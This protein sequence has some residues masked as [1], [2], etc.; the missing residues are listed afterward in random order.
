MTR[1]VKLYKIPEVLET[2]R[3]LD[4]SVLDAYNDSIQSFNE[5]AR[6]TLDKFGK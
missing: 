1:Q 6:Q 4:D 2:A 5:T 3:V